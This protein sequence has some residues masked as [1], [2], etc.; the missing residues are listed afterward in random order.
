MTSFNFGQI[1][2]ALGGITTSLTNLG[3]TPT[4][5]QNS[6]I[7][8]TIGGLMNQNPNKSAEMAICAQILQFASMPTIVD[9]LAMTLATEQGI[10]VA[11]AS[12]AMTLT[13]P[14][15]DVIARTMEIEQIIKG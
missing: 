11:A 3:L 9:K 8:T 2:T 4:Q 10:P 12:L 7:L 13:Q 6:G 1:G 15:V 5:I 14:G